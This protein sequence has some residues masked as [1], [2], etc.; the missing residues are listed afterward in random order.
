MTPFDY[1]FD[2][3]QRNGEFFPNMNNIWVLEYSNS[4]RNVLLNAYSVDSFRFII[5]NV[6]DKDG[7]TGESFCDRGVIKWEY[8]SNL[9]SKVFKSKVLAL[10]PRQ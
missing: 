6:M 4:E 7:C 8:M 1:W 2:Y 10:N 5:C 9:I 3:I